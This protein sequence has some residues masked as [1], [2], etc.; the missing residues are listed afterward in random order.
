MRKYVVDTNDV[1]GVR[2]RA[3]TGTHAPEHRRKSRKPEF[4]SE[5]FVPAKLGPAV[6]CTVRDVS[7]GGARMEMEHLKSA[8]ERSA[9]DIEDAVKAF[10]PREGT[11]V[12]CEIVWRDG[13][14][15]GVKF[16]GE[17]RRLRPRSY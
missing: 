1:H 16:T 17:P 13:R 6:R 5:A 7:A 9:D 11:E 10:F 8:L 4:M 12:P 15:F 14:H 3:G 2:A